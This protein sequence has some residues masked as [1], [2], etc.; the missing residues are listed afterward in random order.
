MGRTESSVSGFQ[1]R[2]RSRSPGK[3]RHRE[4]SSS[5][6]MWG[7]RN[8]TGFSWR[9]HATSAGSMASSDRLLLPGRGL[10]VRVVG[11]G[12]VGFVM[13]DHTARRSVE[14]DVASHV[15]GKPQ[16]DIRMLIV[17]SVVLCI[18]GKGPIGRRDQGAR[19]GHG[20]GGAGRERRDCGECIDTKRRCCAAGRV[21]ARND[22]AR[23][24]GLCNIRSRICPRPAPMRS[25]TDSAKPRSSRASLTKQLP[26]RPVLR[27]CT[28]AHPSRDLLGERR[29][30]CT[31][32]FLVPSRRIDCSRGVESMVSKSHAPA[33]RQS[34]PR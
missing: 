9:V 28:P 3:I 16:F 27:R 31:P 22:G 7:S 30:G 29:L 6:T 11:V 8:G 1:S 33:H 19:H 15:A 20:T 34:A 14:L 23:Q 4:P 21:A 26:D 5:S 2:G 18:A 25:F 12:L 32:D 10:R 24:S 17:I 13:T